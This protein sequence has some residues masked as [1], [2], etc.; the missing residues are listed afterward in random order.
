MFWIEAHFSESPT[1]SGATSFLIRRQKPV[2]GEEFDE[3]R[4]LSRNVQRPLHE[5]GLIQR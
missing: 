3:L 1:I 2:F 4:E 5:E